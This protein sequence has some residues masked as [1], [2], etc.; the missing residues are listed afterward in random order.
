MDLVLAIADHHDPYMPGLL[1][2]QEQAGPLL[3]FLSDQRPDHCIVYLLPPHAGQDETLR[4][5]LN[6]AHPEL[7][8]E[9][10]P[11]ALRNP[12]D[13]E[14]LLQEMRQEAHRLLRAFPFDTVR[15]ACNEESNSIMSVWRTLVEEGSLPAE[16][17]RVGVSQ[18]LPLSGPRI[19]QLRLDTIPRASMLRESSPPQL[20][21]VMEELGCI[22]NHPAYLQA[23]DAALS[24]AA[25]DGV[26]LLRGE[27]GT[28]REALARLIHRM[29]DRRDFDFVWVNCN[30]LPSH[31][32]DS[33]LFGHI[34]GAFVGARQD[35]D[36]KM[37]L[38]HNGTLYLYNLENL[39][40]HIQEALVH[41]LRDGVVRPQGS[42]DDQPR[43]VRLILGTEL[44]PARSL[45]S[46]LL[47]QE[48]HD[49]VADREIILPALRERRTDIPKL[50][51][52]F[53]ARIN[54]SLRHPKRLTVEAL[55]FLENQVWSRNL[56]DL[57]AAIERAALYARDEV[58]HPRDLSTEGGAPNVNEANGLMLPDFTEEF[59]LETYM[60]ELRSRI[61]RKALDESRGNQSEA[62]RL[63][64]IT[65]QAVHQFI[66]R[67]K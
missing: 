49:L 52:H 29:G 67:W 66:K 32:L 18:R 62:A 40:T 26:L 39:P 53:L 23:L 22:G 30:H 47:I 60:S 55:E 24:L 5:A 34:K 43:N 37:G 8:C 14:E 3:S 6:Q 20:E 63:L 21:Y 15:I 58:L 9:I 38:A 56:Q 65:P 64:K 31:Y 7:S 19:E 12:T 17:F 44:Q 16:V 13:R 57:H 54:R 10:R 45:R 46:K 33:V 42:S 61:V 2:H 48:L 27:V 4:A 28:G 36:G 11:L 1:A 25:H 41:Y 35:D 51:L 50:A 59:S